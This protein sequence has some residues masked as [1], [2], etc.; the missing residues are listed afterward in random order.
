MLGVIKETE[1]PE[2]E[3]AANPKK[4]RG[5]EEFVK[6]FACADGG[7]FLDEEKVLYGLLGNRKLTGSGGMLSP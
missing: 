6:I 3:V 1:I 5:T 7:I 2:A 4:Q